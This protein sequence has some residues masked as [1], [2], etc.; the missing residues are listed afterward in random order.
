M[1]CAAIIRAPIWA[2]A[3]FEFA[4]KTPLV[5]Q[6]GTAPACIVCRQFL[7]EL[8]ADVV[9]PDHLDDQEETDRA[10]QL[11]LI[12]D[13]MG[14]GGGQPIEALR[15]FGAYGVDARKPRAKDRM[16]VAG[17]DRPRPIL[18]ARSYVRRGHLDRIEK[19]LTLR[20]SQLI[21]ER[22]PETTRDALEHYGDTALTKHLQGLRSKVTH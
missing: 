9:D 11:L 18:K 20:L 14:L 17:R 5:R 1:D 3:Y 16:A 22:N 21:R 6:L 15:L 4:V 10:I 8:E 19:A 13:A 2:D 12:I 7:G